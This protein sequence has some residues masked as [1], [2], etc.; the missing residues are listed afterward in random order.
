MR[1]FTSLFSDRAR[2]IV[3]A[4]GYPRH[5]LTL[6][7]FTFRSSSSPLI[8]FLIR[9][10]DSGVRFFDPHVLNLHGEF[11]RTRPLTRRFLLFSLTYRLT[12]DTRT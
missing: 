7:Q 10:S 11:R 5:A 9:V 2:I 4:I 8:D 6:L 3:L 1:L 12:E